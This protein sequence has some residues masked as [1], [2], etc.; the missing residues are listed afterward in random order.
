MADVLTNVRK[1]AALPVLQHRTARAAAGVVLFALLTALGAH[2]AIP[3]VGGVPVTLQTMFVTLA[4]ALLGPYLGA[5]SQLLYLAI[6]AAGAPVFAMGGGL[7]YLAGPTG[8]YLL[9]Y[10]LAAA[11]TGLLGKNAG[12][13]ARGY[14]QIAL[15][16]LIASAVTLLLGWAQLSIVTGDSARAYQAGVQP[17]LIGDL[18]KIVLAT[19]IASRI[20][21]RAQ[22]P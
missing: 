13:G 3:L 15:A 4:G 2:V 21:F 1:A 19:L 22:R 10:P 12:A 14:G 11:V 20:K 18:L 7:L 17:F 9:S 16:M 5:A 6:G 8:G